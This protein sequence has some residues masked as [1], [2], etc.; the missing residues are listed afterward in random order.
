MSTAIAETSGAGAQSRHGSAEGARRVGANTLAFARPELTWLSELDE[1]WAVSSAG[2]R[3]Q[4]VREGGRRLKRRLLEGEPARALIAL[5]LARFPYPARF[6]LGGAQWHP[7]PLVEMDHRAL[8]VEFLRGGETKRLLFNPTDVE[9]ARATPFF[10]Q[11]L[12]KI[13]AVLQPVLVARPLP[14][15]ESQLADLGVSVDSIDYVAFDHFHTQDLR[16][17]FRRFPRAKLLAPKREWEAWSEVHPVQ[18]AWYVPN[19]NDGVDTSRVIFTERDLMLGDG[20]ALVRTP[21]HTIGNQTL[22]VSTKRGVWGCAENGTCAD[23]WAPAASRIAGLRRAAK[24]WGTGFALNC[25]TPELYADQ[26]TSMAL[27]SEIVDHVNEAPQFLQMYPSSELCHS[28]LAPG[29]RPTYRHG[30]L[31]IG[32]LR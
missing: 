23:A 17:L 12:A 30:V 24:T 16:A 5:P 20:V 18:S 27:E 10:A 3:L 9:A 11:L 32:G 25:N 15:L 13:P 28:P 21:G 19:G 6:A 31:K 29:L 26:Y 22:F 2:A 14:T 1:A 7:A 4:A 8:L